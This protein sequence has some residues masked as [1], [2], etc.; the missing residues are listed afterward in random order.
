MLV[1]ILVLA[2]LILPLIAESQALA[3]PGVPAVAEPRFFAGVNVPWVNWGCDFG[4]SATNG[5]SAP[6][7]KAEL[8]ARFARLKSANVHTVRWWMFEGEAWQINR[9]ASGAPATLN[10]AVYTDLDAALALADQYDLTYDLVLF[11]APTALPTAWV[12]DAGQR[13]RLANALAPMFARYKNHPRILAWE[14]FNEPEW[15]TWN[16]KIA[17]APVQETVKLLTNT[18]HANTSTAVTIGSANL[19]GIQ[20]WVGLGLDF[21]SPH[22]Y[23]PM[24]SGTACARCTDARTAAGVNHVEGV[25]IVIGEFYGAP[26][27]DTLQR[28]KD[29][30]D[31]GYAGAWAWS[32]FNE[33]TGDK[34]AVDLDAFAAFA[35][36][37]PP[38][39]APAT[40]QP[41]GQS[42]PAQAPNEAGIQLLANWV[43]PTYAVAGDELTMFQDVQAARDARVLVQ[44]EIVDA[45]G[46]RIAQAALDNQSI[47][48]DGITSFS[49]TL[50]LPRTL[51][52]GM[53]SLRTGIYTPGGSAQFV[54]SDVAGAVMVEALPTP[55]PTPMP[56]PT[57]TPTSDEEGEPAE[58]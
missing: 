57:E 13:Q 35:T 25:P 38:S 41:A 12:T 49:A 37:N 20:Q 10:P 3:A 45:Q 58:T 42:R 36:S 11:S 30:R 43:S 52:A 44:F 4:C 39:Q 33:R 51:T 1:R 23:D 9:D 34:M 24:S 8:A 50:A 31:K 19:D 17:L 5:V 40:P 53:Y 48:K 16:N 22:W 47:A 28:L 54:S 14:L 6:G 21:Y 15:D 32:L 56:I 29:F 18:I 46:Q 55:T 27:T 26:E 7:V 2:A